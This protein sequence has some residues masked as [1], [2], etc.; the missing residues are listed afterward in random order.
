MIGINSFENIFLVD[1]MHHDRMITHNNVPHWIQNTQYVGTYFR[2]CNL[3]HSV[4]VY[5]MHFLTN[6]LTTREQVVDYFSERLQSQSKS[7]KRIYLCKLHLYSSQWS[8]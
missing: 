4:L 1:L 3:F 2:N 7:L 6:I 8:K 5:F